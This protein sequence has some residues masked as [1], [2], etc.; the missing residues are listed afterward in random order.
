MNYKSHKRTSSGIPIEV[1]K[2]VN[3]RSGGKCEYS[4]VSFQLDNAHIVHRGMGGAQGERAKLINDT[5][6]IVK[7][8]R[9]Y[10]D[11]IDG[12]IQDPIFKSIILSTVKAAVGWHEWYEEYLE[13]MKKR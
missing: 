7:L 8:N 10:H 4:G 1:I 6:N 13:F 2:A 12:R 5:R 11:I 9:R 3:E